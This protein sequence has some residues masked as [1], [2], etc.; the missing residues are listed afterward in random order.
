MSGVVPRNTKTMSFNPEALHERLAALLAGGGLPGRY[1]VAFSG[2]VDSTVLLHALLACREIHETEILA[3]HVDH[4]LHPESGDWAAHCKAVAAGLGVPMEVRKVVV[5]EDAGSGIEAAARQA[6]YAMLQ[7]MMRDGD[8]LLSAHHEDDQAE[9]LL[10]NLMRGSGLAGLAGIGARQRFGPGVLLRPLLGV[11]GEAIERYADEMNLHWIEDPTNDD[12]R[13]DRNFLRRA[14]VPRL[15]ARW[16]AVS[17]RLRRSADL[18]SEA[19]ELLN[20]LAA[21]DLDAVGDV[22]RINIPA[23]SNLSQAR[24]RNVLRFAV[25]QCGLPP[26][27][28][29]RLYQAIHELIPA[30]ADAQPLIEWPGAELRRY[31]EHLYVLS[32][33]DAVVDAGQEL[34]TVGTPPVALGPGWGCLTL[35]ADG[36]FGIDPQTV[37]A[38]L[39]LRFR[40]G[41][42]EFR[43]CGHERTRKLKKMLQEEGIVPWMRQR[44]PL[45]YA[46]DELVAVADLWI[47]AEFS[48]ER[49]YKV[50]WEGRPALY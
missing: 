36:E 35:E 39:K 11:S 30:R 16:P 5:A 40:S 2:G 19:S 14:I 41:G 31:R 17:A 48:A 22:R 8:C 44:L 13:F 9:T 26:P 49:G 1:L 47:A 6:R 33:G 37:G 4:G 25:R 7:S 21:I 45:L 29:T 15:A 18:A 28:A 10:L 34:L 32:A 46:G 27:P 42:E 3:I 38:G 50:R 12:L 20:E 24:Q 23:L 43:P